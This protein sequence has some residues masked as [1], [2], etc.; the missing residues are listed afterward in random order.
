[1]CARW[2]SFA[3]YYADMG[4]AP[5]GMTLERRD[6]MRGYSPQNCVW[7][8]R[9]RQCRNRRDNR[10]VTFRGES[11]TVPEWAERTGLRGGTIWMRLNRY[12]WTVERA[13]TTPRH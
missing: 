5:P 4:D 6:N 11:L 12:G 2:R 9:K 13:L 3:A 8:T 7:A 1:M 10:F